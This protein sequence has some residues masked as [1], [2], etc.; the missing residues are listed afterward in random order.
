M[1]IYFLVGFC[2][3]VVWVFIGSA[4]AWVDSNRLSEYANEKFGDVLDEFVPKTL[5]ITKKSGAVI[6]VKGVGIPLLE[7]HVDSELDTVAFFKLSVRKSDMGWVVSIPRKLKTDGALALNDVRRLLGEVL[8]CYAQH[9]KAD[10]RFNA[11]RLG[12]KN[13]VSWRKKPIM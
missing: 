10:S 1:G 7:L 5:L 8:T 9:V 3:L 11:M 13:K 4:A 2:V 12:N 6:L